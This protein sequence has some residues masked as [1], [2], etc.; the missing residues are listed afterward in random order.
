MKT[1][2][3]A[4]KRG[5]AFFEKITPFT[6]EWYRNIRKLM[7]ISSPLGGA[8]KCWLTR[9]NQ[10]MDHQRQMYLKLAVIGKSAIARGALLRATK[11]GNIDIHATRELVRWNKEHRTV[12]S[13]FRRL[14]SSCATGGTLHRAGFVVLIPDR[15]GLGLVGRRRAKF[16]GVDF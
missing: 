1:Y 16:E 8:M 11:H 10:S 2:T 13:R 12:W 5:W 7:Q 9:T 6:E 15:I 14:T 3:A 4:T